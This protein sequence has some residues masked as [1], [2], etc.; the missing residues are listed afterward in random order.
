VNSKRRVIVAL[1]V[2]AASLG[3]VAAKGLGNSL[4]YYRTPTEVV[5]LGDQLIGERFRLGGL[6][7]PGSIQHRG[8]ALRFV[9][10]DGTTRIT[11]VATGTVPALFRAGQGVVV[12]GEESRDGTFRADTVLVKHNGVYSPPRPGETPHTADVG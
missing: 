3:W 2:I 10:S 9:V 12:E 5:R 1:V 8:D 4:L 11:V 7:L 6:V